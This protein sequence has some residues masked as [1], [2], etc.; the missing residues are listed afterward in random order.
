MVNTPT[1]GYPQSCDY[2]SVGCLTT[3][4]AV[5]TPFRLFIRANPLANSM[6]NQVIRK[7][8]HGNQPIGGGRLHTTLAD[9]GWL[10]DNI[11][12]MMEN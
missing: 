9:G 5:V 2:P 8:E 1:C 11:P 3:R 6:K 7:I 10:I 4:W 12:P